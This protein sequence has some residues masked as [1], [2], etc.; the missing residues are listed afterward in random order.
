MTAESGGVTQD[1]QA[2]GVSSESIG[3]AM[4]LVVA[5]AAGRLRIL[6]PSQ[7]RDGEEW[8]TAGDT[9]AT[10]DTGAGVRK[11]RAPVTAKVAGAL[12]RD[13]QPVQAGQPL[14]WLEEGTAPALPDRPGGA[15]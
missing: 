1:Q 13:Q 8:V 10:V 6:P 7:F 4:R 5:P 9:M 2:P 14:F 11:A 15:P 12:V 3:L